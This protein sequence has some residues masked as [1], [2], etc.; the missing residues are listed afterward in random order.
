[1]V[2]T[3]IMQL[4]TYLKHQSISPAVFAIAVGVSTTTVYRW[5][6][7]KRFPAR[8]LKHIAKVTRG[9]VTPND[10]LEQ[11]VEPQGKKRARG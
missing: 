1:M 4:Q 3:Q 10:W 6:S 2:M 9:A 11:P 7:G 8:H 5:I